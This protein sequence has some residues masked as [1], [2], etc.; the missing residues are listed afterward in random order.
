MII[1]A[2]FQAERVARAFCVIRPAK[3]ERPLCRTGRNAVARRLLSARLQC[4][5]AAYCSGVCLPYAPGRI[6]KVHSS[7]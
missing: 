7:I 2:S 6:D 1:S 4:N 5:L 3:H